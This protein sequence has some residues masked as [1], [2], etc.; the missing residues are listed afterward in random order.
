[1]KSSSL[2]TR[3]GFLTVL[4]IVL[5]GLSALA[6]AHF[7]KLPAYVLHA[8]YQATM[9]ERELTSFVSS[10]VWFT[11]IGLVVGLI[12]GI[13][14]WRWFRETGWISA[15]AAVAGGLLA[16]L[17]CWGVGELLGPGP[18][19]ARMYLAKPGDLVPVALKLHAPSALAA[20]SFAASAP[21]LFAASLGPERK[22]TTESKTGARPV[23]AVTSPSADPAGTVTA[24]TNDLNTTE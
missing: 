17:V 21:I 12:V 4:S 19:D 5:G 1:M 13:F 3:I 7:S 6:W 18:L 24:S 10:D 11:V 15:L 16:G 2:A 8:D 22:P 23:E 14:T 9:S 20:W